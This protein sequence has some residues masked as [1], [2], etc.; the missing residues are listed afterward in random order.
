MKAAIETETN[1]VILSRW[2]KHRP[3]VLTHNVIFDLDS[4]F[5]KRAANYI[6]VFSIEG[7]HNC[8]RLQ[9]AL[10]NDCRDQDITYE[11]VGIRFTHERCPKLMHAS[12]NNC[13]PQ[14][15]VQ[16]VQRTEIVHEIAAFLKI[17]VV[18]P[19][20]TRKLSAT[21]LSPMRKMDT[22]VLDLIL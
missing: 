10:Q 5:I 12:V 11:A 6:Y 9:S 7:K 22:L 17:H 19:S 4:Q 13:P 2:Q 16:R 1:E 3:G 20:V 8:S 15:Q 18:R 21:C 14:E